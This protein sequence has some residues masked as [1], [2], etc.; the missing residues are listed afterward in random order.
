MKLKQDE[1]VM[2]LEEVECYLIK[3]RNKR[4]VDV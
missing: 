3:G 2:W 4:P 1:N